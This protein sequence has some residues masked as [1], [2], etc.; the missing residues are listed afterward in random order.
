MT[1]G[2]SVATRVEAFWVLVHVGRRTLQVAMHFAT[3]VKNLPQ[4]CSLWSLV[5]PHSLSHIFTIF[6]SLKEKHLKF[7]NVKNIF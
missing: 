7:S 1:Q 3:C 5:H 6:C 4:T 2:G